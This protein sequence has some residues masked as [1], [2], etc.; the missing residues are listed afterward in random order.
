MEYI[1]FTPRLLNLNKIIVDGV[2]CGEGLHLSHWRGNKTPQLYK[3]D[4]S[5]EIALKFVSSNEFEDYSKKFSIVT[6]DHYDTDGVL[7][8]WVILNNEEAIENASILINN[9]ETGD[10]YE[11]TNLNAFK[12]DTIVK[13]FTN[14]NLSPI[15][16]DLVGKS[17]YQKESLAIKTILNKLP[18]LLYD[19]DEYKNL[20]EEDYNGLVNKI[21]LFNT[22]KIKV[23]EYLEEKLSV[24][25][26]PI[27]LDNFARNIFCRGHRI[28]EI[29]PTNNGF[30][31]TLYY[32][33]YLW[34][35]IVL[36][37]KSVLHDLSDLAIK[38]NSIEKNAHGTWVI[39]KWTPALFFIT[40]DDAISGSIVQSY[41]SK[42]IES[43]IQPNLLIKSIC[44]MLN[45]LDK[46]QFS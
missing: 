46:I 12:F 2:D 19:V 23:N 28:L 37:P 36:K 33:E 11:Y 44:E 30:F 29:I 13:E 8:A 45:L 3:A 42:K 10:F 35:D 26:T 32:R 18:N 20:W 15:K 17:K 7:A 9:A 1:H 25:F 41:R 16:K 22:N 40:K 38:L 5:V 43:F 39:T 31:Y 21:E 4:L 34:Y 27:E 6:N 24:I 14:E